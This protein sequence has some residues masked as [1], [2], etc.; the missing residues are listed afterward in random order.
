MT[1]KRPR[2]TRRGSLNSNAE[3]LVRMSSGLFES[4]SRIEE[5]YWE[6][7]LNTLIDQLL[8]DGSETIISSALDHLYSADIPV[9]EELADLVESRV[10]CAPALADDARQSVLIAAPVL[11]WSR[12]HIPAASIAP[13]MLKALRAHLHAHVLAQDTRLA[14]ADFFFSPDQLPQ[15]YCATAELSSAL[16]EAALRGQDLH[17]DPATLAKTEHFLSDTR[18]LLAAVSAPRD[19]AVFIWQER[20]GSR[21]HAHAQWGKQAGACILPLF[22]GCALEM[23]LPETYFAAS[24][25]ADRAARAYSVRGSVSF[26]GMEFNIPAANLQATIAPFSDRK[27]Q[28]YRIGFSLPGSDDIAHGVVW[29]LLGPEDE[30]SDIA[31]EIETILR[32]AGIN[33]ITCL[34]HHFPPEYCEDCGTPLFPA[35]DGE[36][37]HAEMPEQSNEPLSRH[38]H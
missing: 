13:T 16:G 18:Y 28:E 33:D 17:I 31:T 32:E 12:Y 1:T 5:H 27:L 3:R 38:L 14:L 10:E 11:A 36:L 8:L 29:P 6:K 24:S 20:S 23:V 9:F 30:N 35:P 22:P 15:G 26:L 34:E 25:Q 37:V 19:E 2:P 21:A 4:A 7:R